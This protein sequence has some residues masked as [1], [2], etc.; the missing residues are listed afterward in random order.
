MP[1]A[2]LEVEFESG[3]GSGSIQPDLG[4]VPELPCGC[5]HLTF[6]YIMTE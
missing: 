1:E 6:R 3:S 5:K 2:E 4:R